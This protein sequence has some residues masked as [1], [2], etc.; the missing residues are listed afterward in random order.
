MNTVPNILKYPTIYL[1]FTKTV[2]SPVPSL[3]NRIK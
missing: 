1:C 3:G 2:K